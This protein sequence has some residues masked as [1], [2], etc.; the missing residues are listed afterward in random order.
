[1][2]TSALTLESQSLI[3]LSELVILKL[4]ELGYKLWNPEVRETHEFRLTKQVSKV[5]LGPDVTGQLLEKEKHKIEQKLK[6]YGFIRLTPHDINSQ[7]VKLDN[8][9]AHINLFIY[10]V[11]EGKIVVDG[12]FTIIKEQR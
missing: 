10:S 12:A 2:N 3:K 4:Q 7:P 5:Y 11:M 6:R 1:M 9:T 8:H